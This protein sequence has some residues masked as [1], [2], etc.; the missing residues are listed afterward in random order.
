MP[1][2]TCSILNVPSESV[3]APFPGMPATENVGVGHGLS[4]LS[5]DD[6]AANGIGHGSYHGI[7][8]WA[9]T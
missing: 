8:G 7:H 9:D 5:V 2:G 6:F 3:D 1:G 4:G